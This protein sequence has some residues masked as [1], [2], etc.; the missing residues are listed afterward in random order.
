MCSCSDIKQKLYSE[1]L[2]W[3]CVQFVH[4]TW[5]W[6]VKGCLS[7][8]IKNWFETLDKQSRTSPIVFK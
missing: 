7:I 5:L 8:Q 6:E 1:K 3:E 2:V 4:T